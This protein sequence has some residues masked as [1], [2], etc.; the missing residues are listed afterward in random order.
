MRP[1]GKLIQNIRYNRKTLWRNILQN[2]ENFYFSYVKYILL[3]VQEQGFKCRTSTWSGAFLKCF[4]SSKALFLILPH[5]LSWLLS[6]LS[7]A[8][9]Q[10]Y[11]SS[12]PWCRYKLLLFPAPAPPLLMWVWPIVAAPPRPLPPPSAFAR[13]TTSCWGEMSSR[14]P[15][16]QE[17]RPPCQRAVRGMRWP[18]CGAPWGSVT[19]CPLKTNL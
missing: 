15:W 9:E 11:I 14:S 13:R 12:Q 8:R 6:L 7:S 2:N 3:I 19:T 1:S 10:Q 17:V 4:Y 5:R 18:V 16:K